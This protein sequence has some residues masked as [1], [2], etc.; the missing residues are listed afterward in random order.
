MKIVGGC[1]IGDNV[2]IGAGACILGNVKIG[3]NVRIGANAIVLNDIPDNAVVVGVP[4]KIV[5]LEKNI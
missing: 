1:S 4:G 2:L 3:N 5:R